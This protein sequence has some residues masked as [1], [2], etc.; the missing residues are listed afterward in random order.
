MQIIIVGLR[1]VIFKTNLTVKKPFEIGI[2]P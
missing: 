1:F 2:Y